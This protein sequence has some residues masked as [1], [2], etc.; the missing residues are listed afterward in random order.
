MCLGV[1]AETT[2]GSTVKC[3]GPQEIEDARRVCGILGINHYV[4]D[5]SAEL[6][7]RVIKPFLKEYAQ[8]RTPNP[9]VECNRYLKFGSLFN[10][11]QSLGFDYIATGHYARLEETENGFAMMTPKDHKKDQTYF[12]Y[13]IPRRVLP[14]MMFPLAGYAKH[15]VREIAKKSRLPVFE[16]F[17]SQD[18]CFIPEEGYASFLESRLGPAAPGDIV[19]SEGKVL[20]QHRGIPYYTIGQRSGLGISYRVPL[21]VLSVDADRNR[22]IVGGKI[23]LQARELI[24][25]DLNI[26]V[27]ELPE[28]ALAKIRYAHRAA[29]CRIIRENQNLRIV[30]DKTQESIT[31]GQSVVL[32]DG[33]VVLGGGII[34][35][36]VHGHQ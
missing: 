13:A 11:A 26:L 9:C 20:G 10:K 25:E 16:K 36:V 5:F 14:H 28:N 30:F 12:L 3:C 1:P 22:I 35:E 4:M 7:E 15:E 32:Y 18:I 21:Y 31:P 33:E 2:A 19:D 29:K 27:D 23:D 6:E 34:K 24:A 17:E 8:G